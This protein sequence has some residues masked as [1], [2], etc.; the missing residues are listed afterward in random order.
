[1]KRLSIFFVLAIAAIACGDDRTVG[2][3]VIKATEGGTVRIGSSETRLEVPPNSLGMD[4]EI[5]ATL[6]TPASY[7]AIEGLR[8]VLVLEPAGTALE[9]PATLVWKPSGDALDGTEE[10]AL[11][12]LVDGAW[13][14]L[15]VSVGVG[16]GGLA[17]TTVGRLGTLGL[18]V[19]PAPVGGGT[20]SG[21]VRHIY[22]EEPL[23]GVSFT[24]YTA[25]ET[26]VGTAVSGADGTFSF[27]GLAAGS[28]LVVANV[29]EEEN[30]FGDPTTR[31]V[32]VSEGG[33]ANVSFAFVLNDCG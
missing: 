13:A 27:S 30:C 16:S 24:L 28:Y 20:I 15:D 12:E 22:T 17:T 1:M 21:T 33:T 25:T 19:R 4:T 31:S 26:M 10:L 14:P 2:A 8:E 9:I 18:T 7:P 29:T 32:E 23:A 6:D 5:V 3:T 11:R